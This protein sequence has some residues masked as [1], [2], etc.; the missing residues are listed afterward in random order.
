M[1][2]QYFLNQRVKFIKQLYVISS[3]VYI[4]RKRLIESNEVPFAAP[5]SEDPEP[6]FLE[7]WLEAEESL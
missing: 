6:P 7:D 3:A 2:I 5:Y 4:E 1:D